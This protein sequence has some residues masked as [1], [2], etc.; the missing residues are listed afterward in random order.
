MK[1]KKITRERNMGHIQ[2]YQKF[3]KC[4]INRNMLMFVVVLFLYG[5]TH[6]G[7]EAKMEEKECKQLHYRTKCEKV[8]KASIDI[9]KWSYL[10]F[11]SVLQVDSTTIL[12]SYKRGEA[13]GGD[14]G[15]KLEM[16]RYDVKSEKIIETKIIG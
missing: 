12:I 3:F 10:G 15:A 6:A 5:T 7:E 11:P 4:F 8:L 1:F 16:M 9:D 2:S 13:H 14:P